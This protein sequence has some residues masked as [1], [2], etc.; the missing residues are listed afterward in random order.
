MSWQYLNKNMDK[1]TLEEY[2]KKLEGFE[3][4]L[5][6]EDEDNIDESFMNEVSETLNKLTSDS[7][8][9]VQNSQGVGVGDT[10][11]TPYEYSIGCKFKK[12]HKDAVTP[13][14]SKK[15]DGC[16][17]LHCVSYTL[18]EQTNQVTYSTGISL[19]IPSGYVGLVFPRSSIRRTVLELS[20]SVGVIDS[21][22]RGEIM[23]T[24]NINKGSNQSTI[25]ENGERICQLMILPYPK[26]KFTEVT[27]LSETDRG[28]G[29]FGSTGK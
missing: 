5:S 25:Y 12:L 26:I 2:L 15:G 18:N 3:E 6:E 11:N 17:D 23:A 8:D 1:K 24:F 20:N 21:G 16:V 10:I 19:E 27:E 7:M 13:T 28:E 29:G 22:Y 9:H 14:Y 4:I